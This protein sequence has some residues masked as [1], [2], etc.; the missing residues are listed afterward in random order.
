MPMIVVLTKHLYGT[1]VENKF[2]KLKQTNNFSRF[3]VQINIIDTW[4]SRQTR[5]F[6]YLNS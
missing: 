1:S 2:E 4:T 3:D 6:R 5:H